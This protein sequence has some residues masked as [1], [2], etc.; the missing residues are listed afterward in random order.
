MTKLYN[1]LAVLSAL[2]IAATA[3]GTNINPVMTF[4]EPGF[5]ND[6]IEEVVL[7]FPAEYS[8][9]EFSA[10]ALLYYDPSELVDKTGRIYF[11][12]DEIEQSQDMYT[13]RIE[14]T[15]VTF[16][17]KE[18][19][20]IWGKYQLMIPAG[21]LIF[22]GADG[23]KVYN[24]NIIHCV[25]KLGV[26]SNPYAVPEP[27]DVSDLGIFTLQLP[28][29]CYF[30][31]GYPMMAKFMPSVYLSNENG[32]L[33]ELAGKYQTL[34][35]KETW[36]GSDRVIYTDLSFTPEYGQYYAVW[37]MPY[38]LSIMDADGKMAAAEQNVEMTF[39]YHYCD[40]DDHGDVT[41][42]STPRD[43]DTSAYNESPTVYSID[44]V[45][46]HLQN[47]SDLSKGLWIVN[48]KKIVIR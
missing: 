10:D 19:W 8:S 31:G 38:M 37:F 14:G 2:L 43:T 29:G 24:S 45:R 41:G 15:R 16:T 48:G 6:P 1:Y 17:P 47:I 36:K 5:I 13:A 26:L 21:A 12:G 39:L 20:T 25:W 27:G 4:P 46:H 44:G 22:T 33:V 34:A 23:H 28:E 35:N 42:I 9:I 40:P 3:A 30:S 32:D 11:G 18:P 7:E